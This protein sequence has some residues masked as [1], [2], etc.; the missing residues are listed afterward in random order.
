MQ[1]QHM[2]AFT[3]DIMSAGKMSRPDSVDLLPSEEVTAELE[4]LEAI[5]GADFAAKMA[6]DA[7]SCTLVRAVNAPRGDTWS[8]WAHA[9]CLLHAKLC[10]A[11][12]PHTNRL[13]M[14][15]AANI[16]LTLCPVR[17]TLGCMLFYV[18]FTP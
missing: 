14:V 17:F 4:V 1:E 11:S 10:L 6:V 16:A 9:S 7:V 12:P 5:Y 15:L 18:R 8:C 2:H 13:A 3:R